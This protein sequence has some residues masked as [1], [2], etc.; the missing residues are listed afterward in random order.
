VT[1]DCRVL[2]SVGKVPNGALNKF[3]VLPLELQGRA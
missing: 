1:T 3:S 2:V